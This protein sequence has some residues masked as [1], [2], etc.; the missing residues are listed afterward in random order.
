LRKNEK[1]RQNVS[2]LLNCPGPKISHL[3]YLHL[4]LR[5][6]GFSQ[7][8]KVNLRAKRYENT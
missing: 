8:E 2:A 1:P 7:W 5:E 3:Q 4:E 6:T